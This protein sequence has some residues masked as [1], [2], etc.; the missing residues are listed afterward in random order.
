MRRQIVL[1]HKPHV[2]FQMFKCRFFEELAVLKMMTERG[3]MNS[4]EKGNTIH[5]NF[6]TRHLLSKGKET[7]T[8]EDHCDCRCNPCWFCA[9]TFELKMDLIKHFGEHWGT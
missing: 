3:G 6:V 1:R 4:H 5:A 7:H 8:I 9:K 2:M